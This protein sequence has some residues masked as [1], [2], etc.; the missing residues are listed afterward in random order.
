MVYPG[1]EDWVTFSPGTIPDSIIDCPLTP[2]QLSQPYSLGWPTHTEAEVAEGTLYASQE[3]A[4]KE[5]LKNPPLSKRK[6]EDR[7]SNKANMKGKAQSTITVKSRYL[8]EFVGFAHKWLGLNPTYEWV[9]E[10]QV[11]ARFLGFLASKGLSIKT[12]SN[13]A[14]DLKMAFPFVR[15][16][17]PG[18]A[19]WPDEH[20]VS[21]DAWYSNLTGKLRAEFEHVP[22]QLIDITLWSIWEQ[23]NAMWVDWK[24]RY[25][26][27]GHLICLNI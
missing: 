22:K 23:S 14:T 7:A 26:V 15:D 9:A 10:P 12:M 18:D 2:N 6:R 20:M 19:E 8:R 24:E 21:T 1:M 17:C 3:A 16:H 13:V 11:V 5:F 25:Q 4:F 27:C